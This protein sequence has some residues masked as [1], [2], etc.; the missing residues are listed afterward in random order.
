MAKT[1][2]E[3]A[4]EALRRI[5]VVSS[6]ETAST[7]DLTYVEAAWDAL[8]AEFGSDP[9]NFAVTW[10]VDTVPDYLFRPVAWLLGVQIAQHYQR[11]AEDERRAW[12]RVRANIFPDDRP[13]WR[14]YDEDGTVTEAE[15][16][17]SERAKFY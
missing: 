3:I 4:T 9:H 2:T 15:E 14:D 12:M 5:N 8:F 11:P 7:A 6:K 10:T 16:N 13:D 17:A 1:G